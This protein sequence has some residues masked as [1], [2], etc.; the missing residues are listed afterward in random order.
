MELWGE[1]KEG[2]EFVKIALQT[3]Y[4]FRNLIS[5]ASLPHSEKLGCYTG[6]FDIHNPGRLL[7]A[8][9]PI[10]FGTVLGYIPQLVHPA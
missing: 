7:G 9:L 4:R 6:A 5:P 8:T 2:D 10:P 1:L 3:G